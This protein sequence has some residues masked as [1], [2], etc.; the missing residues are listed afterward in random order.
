MQNTDHL[1][2]S[3]APELHLHPNFYN[4]Q[5][6]AESWTPQELLRWA[7][8][9][10]GARMEIASAFGAEGIALI[11]IASRVIKDLK[12]FILDTGFLFPE[13][14]E[15]LNKVEQR[16][17]IQVERVLADVGVELQGQ[18]YEPALWKRDPDLCCTIRKVQP[19]Q[20]KLAGLKAWVTAIRR[21]QTRTRQNVRKVEWDTNFQLIK[22]NPLA[23]WTQ[24]MVWSYIAEHGLSY[25]PL[26]DQNYPSIGCI[27]CTRPIENGEDERAGR[28]SGFQKQECG[29]HVPNVSG[30]YAQ[31]AF[32]PLSDIKV[33]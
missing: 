18:L 21:D 10:F 8:G 26:H 15:L 28:W 16:Y 27:H 4:I 33:D 17:G 25:N 20:K 5:A 14:L 32:I 13:T 23:D 9:K 1:G 6:M 30:A 3:R 2:E 12:I 11:E 19:L 22:I 7:A 29:L 24:Q 31:A